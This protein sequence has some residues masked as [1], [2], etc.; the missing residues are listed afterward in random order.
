MRQPDHQSPMEGVSSL[1]RKHRAGI[2]LVP[3]MQPA[4]WLRRL[5]VGDD[6]ERLTAAEPHDWNG[7]MFHT[8][9]FSILRVHKCVY[10]QH[11]SFAPR[12]DND[13]IGFL[14]GGEEMDAFLPR[15]SEGSRGS[16]ATAETLARPTA[17]AARK[18]PSRK[19]VRTVGLPNDANIVGGEAVSTLSRH[20]LHTKRCMRSGH[21]LMDA[22]PAHAVPTPIY[23][24]I[25][26]VLPFAIAAN[27]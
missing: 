18:V 6:L 15:K 22:I 5:R 4:L 3:V 19:A 21:Q 25:K 2:D 23:P 13:V 1:K 9:G 26:S 20:R 17:R 24:S 14:R 16:R 12:P 11:C 8:D 27:A 10:V 7:G